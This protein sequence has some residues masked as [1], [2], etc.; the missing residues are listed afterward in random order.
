MVL[1]ASL[2]FLGQNMFGSPI[3]MLFV[4]QIRRTNQ[5]LYISIVGNQTLIRR[6]NHYSFASILGNQTS[7]GFGP[8]QKTLATNTVRELQL[9]HFISQGSEDN[10]VLLCHYVYNAFVNFTAQVWYACR[11]H[12]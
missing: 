8:L 11:S 3:P 10:E 6:T 1:N 7:F 4:L 9:W 12:T 2:N 5:S